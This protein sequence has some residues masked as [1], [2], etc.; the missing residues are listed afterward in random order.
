MRRSPPYVILFAAPIFFA[1]GC[2]GGDA[3]SGESVFAFQC[4]V[5]H[6]ADGSGGIQIADTTGVQD[7]GA[8]DT[9]GAGSTPSA[10]L[11]ERVPQLADE[12]ILSV[13]RDGKG[14]MPSQ[15]G[16]DDSEAVDVLAYLRQTFEP[17]V[18]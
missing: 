6:N 16:E 4:A 13:L 3:E 18:E 1:T 12:Y 15:F 7:T 11:R 2:L 9:G 10:D 8:V 17:K 5:C 14:N